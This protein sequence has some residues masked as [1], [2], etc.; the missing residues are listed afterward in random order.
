MMSSTNA[1]AKFGTSATLTEDTFYRGAMPVAHG[2][3]TI[4]GGNPPTVTFQSTTEVYGVNTVTSIDA[5]NGRVRIALKNTM[6]ATTYTVVV[7]KGPAS[8]GS[9]SYRVHSRGINSFDVQ[10]L[11]SAGVARDL[12]DNGTFG[13]FS[14]LVLG[15]QT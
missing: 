9:Y 1:S 5:A 14:F 15:R 2:N 12:E 3:V 11:D 7:A 4:V 6:G 8:I 13:D 10:V